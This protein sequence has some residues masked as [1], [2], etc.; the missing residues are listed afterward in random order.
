MKHTSHTVQAWL[1][2]LF[3][4]E[5]EELQRLVQSLPSHPIVVNLGAGAGTSGLAFMESREDITLYTVDIQDESSPHG[6]L[7]GE[8]N[9]FRDAGFDHL[10]GI[11]WFQIHSD[12]A[13]AGHDWSHEPVDMVFIDADHAEDAV[14]GD[15]E[16]WLPRIK[17][18][19]LMSLHDY[20]Q[21]WPDV[22][23]VVD[24]L[25]APN[26]KV[27]SRI[28]STI[29]FRIVPEEPEKLARKKRA[30]VKRTRRQET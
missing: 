26:Y 21:R 12:S 15:I 23:R 11:R 1:Q 7:A 4:G 8:R 17:H 25:L 10:M 24:E 30:P 18:G 19:G 14:R 16:A 13:K 28:S 5:I 3:E 6:C 27:V 22:M 2:Y 29:T 20:G 9:V